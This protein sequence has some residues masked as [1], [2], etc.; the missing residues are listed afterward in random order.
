MKYTQPKAYLELVCLI[1]LFHASQNAFSE[2][3]IINNT[4]P[5]E[6]WIGTFAGVGYSTTS[7]D[8]VT[9]TIEFPLS[10]PVSEPR[11][12][13][14]RNET[15]AI[16]DDILKSDIEALLDLGANYIDI[17]FNTDRLAAE[18][19]FAHIN[20]DKDFAEKILEHLINIRNAVMSD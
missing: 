8:W 10:A 18:V 3:H 4:E 16:D 13:N 17:G 5:P 20:V 6:A 15:P 12:I 2:E 1:C 14:A 7:Y 19:P 11:E 9:V